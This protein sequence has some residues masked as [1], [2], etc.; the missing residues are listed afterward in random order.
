MIDKIPLWCKD[1]PV[2]RLYKLKALHDMDERR[3]H[4]KSE[5]RSKI[6]KK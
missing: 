5:E 3:E 1:L 6:T 4:K 2:K